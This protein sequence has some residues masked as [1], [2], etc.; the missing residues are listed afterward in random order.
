MGSMHKRVGDFQTIPAARRG[1][2]IQR[3]LVD[4]WSPQQTAQ[5]F[6]LSE[7]QVTAWIADYRRYGMTS[8]QRGD[9]SIEAI[10]RRLVFWVRGL[11]VPTLERLR[12]RA[13]PSQTGTCVVLR[14]TGDAGRIRR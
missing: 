3:V 2:I 6:N 11:I 8:L 10:P 7:R 14:R 12:R 1:H 9:L 13:V 5:T 4:G